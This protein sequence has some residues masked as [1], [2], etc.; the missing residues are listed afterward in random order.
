MYALNQTSNPMAYCRYRL[1]KTHQN[2]KGIPAIFGQFFNLCNMLQWLLTMLAETRQLEKASEKNATAAVV[3]YHTTHL[4]TLLKN[5]N[6]N[7]EQQAYAIALP[8]AK[9]PRK[10]QP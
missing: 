2:Q 10:P 1:K 4:L 3:S 5:T 6:T 9:R 7:P 8:L